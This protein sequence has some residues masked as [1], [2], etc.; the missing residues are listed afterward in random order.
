MAVDR[1]RAYGQHVTCL[2]P[3]VRSS[4]AS[5]AARLLRRPALSGWRR[6][7]GLL[8]WPGGVVAAVDWIWRELIAGKPHVEHALWGGLIA[9]L[10]TALGTLPAL[11]PLGLALALAAGAMIYVIGHDVIPQAQ[12]GSH[13]RLAAVALV[14]RFALMLLLDTALG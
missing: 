5:P 4:T 2:R 10:A 12:Q 9:A 3:R 7:L 13:A 11:L 6:A 8:I 1:G 14:G